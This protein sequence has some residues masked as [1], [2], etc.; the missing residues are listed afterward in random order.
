MDASQR[1]TDRCKQTNP[2]PSL[3][4]QYCLTSIFT[5]TLIISREHFV[6]MTHLNWLRLCFLNSTTFV[7]SPLTRK[8]CCFANP[9]E[10]D[11]LVNWSQHKTHVVSHPDEWLGGMPAEKPLKCNEPVR[12]IFGGLSISDKSPS[13]RIM[14]LCHTNPAVCSDELEPHH[15]ATLLLLETTSVSLE[16]C[17]VNKQ[18]YSCPLMQRL[19]FVLY[20]LSEV[21]TPFDF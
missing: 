8:Q 11:Y 2:P 13:C 15:T 4:S 21:N 9:R 19:M 17:L 14:R 20:S 18:L 3:V 16:C 5:S 7:L 10:P 1:L 12:L 6:I